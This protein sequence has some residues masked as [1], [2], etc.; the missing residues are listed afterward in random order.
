MQQ[1]KLVVTVIGDTSIGRGFAK[2]LA[3]AGHRILSDGS[4][5]QHQQVENIR[6][7]DLVVLAIAGKDLPALIAEF[8]EADRWRPGQLV[9]HTAGEYG[10]SVLAPAVACGVVPLAI[11]PAMQFGD[12]AS[13]AI[14]IRESYFVVSAPE[15]ALPIA[16]AIVIEM[17]AEPVTIA[18]SD[19]ATYFE[20]WSVANDFSGLV[21]NQA[22]GLLQ[23]IGV[24]DPRGLIGPVVRASVEKALADGH[25]PIEIDELD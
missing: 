12:T 7:S 20:A 2:V 18:E 11:H 16:Q 13:D 14:M 4:T 3:A 1:P 10:Y 25:T 23:Q 6:Q 19:R 8:T 5:G 21:V 9:A 24:A 15:P 17:G 22:I